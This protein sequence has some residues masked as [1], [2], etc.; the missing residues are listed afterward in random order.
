MTNK[1][2]MTLAAQIAWLIICVGTLAILLILILGSWG[3]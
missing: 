3:C 1:E 2:T